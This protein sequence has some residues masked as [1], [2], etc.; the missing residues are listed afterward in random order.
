MK[1]ARRNLPI[2]FFPVLMILILGPIEVYSGN[3]TD[4]EFMLEDFIWLFL[5]VAVLVLVAGTLFLALLPEKVCRFL[6]RLLF[7]FSLMAYLQYLFLNRK[8]AMGDGT[9]MD[10]R[11]LHKESVINMILWI[12][13]LIGIYCGIHFLIKSLEIKYYGVAVWLLT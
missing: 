10:W 2:V 4:F 8:L 5:G 3:I 11:A 13:F 9:A 12:V 1:R 7:V 6:S